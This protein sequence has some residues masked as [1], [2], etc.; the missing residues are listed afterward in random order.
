L[1]ERR[2]L[3]VSRKSLYSL[4]LGFVPQLEHLPDHCVGGEL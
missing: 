2:L 4:S 3:G 1:I